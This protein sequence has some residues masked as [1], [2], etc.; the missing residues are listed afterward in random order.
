MPAILHQTMQRVW[1]TA[2]LQ[3][4]RLWYLI[5][6]ENLLWPTLVPI[7]VKASVHIINVNNKPVDCWIWIREGQELL[8]KDGCFGKGILSRS[9]PTWQQRYQ[10][11]TAEQS[12]EN[13]PQERYI[14]DI[15]QRRR[16]ARRQI[17]ENTNE[18]QHEEDITPVVGSNN[19]ISAQDTMR[20]EKMNDLNVSQNEVDMMEPVQL[21]PFEALFL[22]DIGCLE[23]LDVSHENKCLLH[24]E[25]YSLLYTCHK[26]DDFDLKYAAYYYYRA[27]GWVVRSGLKFGSDFLLYGKGGPA[28]SH[29]Q[30]SV[31]VRKLEQQQS[32]DTAD[33]T[34]SWQHMFGLSRVCTQVRKSLIICYVNSYVLKHQD[35]ILPDLYQFEIQEYLFKRFNPNRK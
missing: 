35:S 21:S 30:Y 5:A 13:K 31:V 22:S 34:E 11:E 17:R 8:W 2:T 4:Q 33:L 26:S 9:S 23:A 25:L 10:R 15:T 29:S 32:E 12:A 18:K 27:K 28:R 14:E 24:T 1:R 6:K 7:R 3:M 16:E 20:L 19:A